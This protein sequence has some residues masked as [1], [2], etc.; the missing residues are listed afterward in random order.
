MS[1]NDDMEAPELPSTERGARAPEHQDQTGVGT[2]R[3]DDSGLHGAGLLGDTGA[4]VDP[5]ISTGATTSSHPAAA[6]EVDINRSGGGGTGGPSTA[7]P[8]MDEALGGDPG[9]GT[10]S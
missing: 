8:D 10:D 6:D 5:A 7:A 2:P 9:E 1:R 3:S 4:D